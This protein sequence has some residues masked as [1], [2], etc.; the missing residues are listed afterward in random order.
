ML[1]N[2]LVFAS[3]LSHHNSYGT[4]E[5]NTGFI[6]F[7]GAHFSWRNMYKQ[8]MSHYLQTRLAY[9]VYFCLFVI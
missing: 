5:N 7:L 9:R 6:F 1:V 8:I 4:T 2:I 3:K